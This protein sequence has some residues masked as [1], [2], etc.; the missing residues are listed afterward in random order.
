MREHLQ[1]MEKQSNSFTTLSGKTYTWSLDITASSGTAA[2]LQS[3]NIRKWHR[4]YDNPTDVPT[5]E[6]Y[7][8]TFTATSSNNL[9]QLNNGG[10][11]SGSSTEFDNISVRLAEEDRSVNGNGLQVFGTVTKSAVATGADLVS[12]NTFSGGANPICI[13][14]TIVILEFDEL[15]LSLVECSFW[16][17]GQQHQISFIASV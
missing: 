2:D 4:F 8:V 5:L 15:T 1:I 9:Y 16:F 11:V 13:S 14:H 12:Y 17:K 10:N 6:L 3:R 7:S